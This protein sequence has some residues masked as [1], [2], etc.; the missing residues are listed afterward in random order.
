[1]TETTPTLATEQRHDLAEEL[2]KTARWWPTPLGHDEC[3]DLALG[4]SRHVA[5][6]VAEAWDQAH[7]V[8]CPRQGACSVHLRPGDRH[9]LAALMGQTNPLRGQGAPS[10]ASGGCP[11]V[12]DDNEPQGE[13]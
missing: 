8:F 2:R 1:M 10:T 3:A 11:D 13:R 12:R 4:L 5:H 7:D 9:M 6:M